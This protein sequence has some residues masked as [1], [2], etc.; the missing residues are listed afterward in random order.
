MKMA[1]STPISKT[2]P[3]YRDPAAPVEARVEDLL[4]RMTLREKVM[5]MRLVRGLDTD[6]SATDRCRD[7]WGASHQPADKT[8]LEGLNAIQKYL[9]GKTRLGIPLLMV[10]EALHGLRYQGCTVFPQSIALGATF[11]EELVGQIAEAIGAEARAVGIRQVFAPNLD[12]ARDPRWGRTEETYGEDSFLASRLGVAYVRGVQSAGV[13]ATPKHFVAHGSPEGGINLSPVHMGEREMR[14]RTL[15]VFAAAFREGGALS[16]MPCYS[17]LDGVPVHASRHLLT[18][19]LRGELGFEGYT[20]SDFGALDM[21]K[22]FH[23]VAATYLDAA[24]LGL[25]AGVDM[26]GATQAA[27][28]DNFL[29]AAERGEIDLAELDEAVRRILRVKFKL[30]L[31]EDPCADPAAPARVVRS[32]AHRALARRA[33][34][35]GAVL[36]ENDGFLPLDAATCGRVLVVGPSGGNAPLGD[37]TPHQSLGQ[38]VSLVDALRERLGAERVSYAPGCR[39][40]SGDDDAL[41]EAV[42][43]ADEADVVLAAVGDNSHIFYGIGWEDDEEEVRQVTGGEGYDDASLDLPA[44]QRR[45]LAALAET[46]KPVVVVLLSGRPRLID[47]PKSFRAILEGWYPGEE[48]G[49]ALADIL[50]G[51]LSPSGRLPLSFPRSA[52]HIPCCYDHKPSAR[53]PGRKA[54]SPDNPGGAYLFSSPEPLYPFGYGLSYTKFAYSDL[55]VEPA[56]VPV[57]AVAPGAGDAATVT[58]RVANVGRRAADEVALLF[59]SDDVCSVTPFVRRL[60]GFRRV[61]LAPGESRDVTFAIGFH[62]LSFIG[63]DMREAVEPGTF[64]LSVGGLQAVFELTPGNNPHTPT[65][66]QEQHA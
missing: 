53:G 4:S 45:L 61:A 44:P 58:V 41:A 23:R 15:P 54:G 27:Y 42:A 21:L 32:A 37:Y 2:E 7:G 17:E 5:Q 8:S 57:D 30:G 50:L 63:G 52:G 46:G 20:I 24:R 59:V 56:C 33:A 6:P 65:P 43:A 31:F 38:A 25:H 14:E 51:D 55:R 18:D 1:P 3:L 29:E 47:A 39:Y 49:R 64:T 12:L 19:I 9:L 60:R 66:S 16:A 40:T 28:D 26:E 48:G 62:D 13:A 34:A 11:D 10:G 22:G 36:L 35:E